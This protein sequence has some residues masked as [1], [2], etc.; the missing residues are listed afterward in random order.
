MRKLDIRAKSYGHV[1]ISGNE[2]HSKL[3]SNI[4]NG[5][6]KASKRY[7]FF[8]LQFLFIVL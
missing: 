2:G 6:I 4:C 1:A 3:G 7:S 5:T 8:I